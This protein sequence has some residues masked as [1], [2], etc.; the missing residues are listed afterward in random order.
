MNVQEIQSHILF[1]IC[2][3]IT[4][5]PQTLQL[6]TESM[7]YLTVSVGQA[8]GHSLTGCLWS[9]VSHKTETEMVADCV[10]P[11]EALSRGA[12][13]FKLIQVAAVRITFLRCC[14]TWISAEHSS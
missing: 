11:S 2:C 6:T 4:D 7:Y 14:I 1:V 3:C 13:V 9:K 5:Y 8:F 12:S 10:V